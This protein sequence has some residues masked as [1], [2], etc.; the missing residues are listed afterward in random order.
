MATR[1]CVTRG[2]AQTAAIR[3]EAATGNMFVAC[4]HIV[5]MRSTYAPARA[6]LYIGGMSHRCRVPGGNSRHAAEMTYNAYNDAIG[7]SL[8][9]HASH[10]VF[11]CKVSGGRSRHA[12]E[13]IAS[14]CDDTSG[15]S[16]R[17]RVTSFCTRRA[18]TELC[19]TAPTLMGTPKLAAL[20]AQPLLASDKRCLFFGRIG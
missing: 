4:G 6:K 1:P 18:L 8:A 9:I 2:Y 7:H 10:H 19:Q 12:A 14:T 15:D 5:D 16:Q 3:G 13:T 11:L 20:R 17:F